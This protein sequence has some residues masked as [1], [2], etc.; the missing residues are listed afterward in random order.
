MWWIIGGLIGWSTRKVLT[1]HNQAK[2]MNKVPDWGD[3]SQKK[4]NRATYVVAGATL[5][6]A[7][8]LAQASFSAALYISAVGVGIIGMR[9]GRVSVKNPPVTYFAVG[10]LLVIGLAFAAFSPGASVFPVVWAAVIIWSRRSPRSFVNPVAAPDSSSSGVAL[11][12]ADPYPAIPEVIDAAEGPGR[13]SAG[14]WYKT[15]SQASMSETVEPRSGRP[16]KNAVQLVT[17]GWVDLSTAT[18]LCSW[19]GPTQHLGK[20]TFTVYRTRRGSLVLQEPATG[21]N[22]GLLGSSNITYQ[23]AEGT[24][25]QVVEVM[26]NKGAAR[27]ARQL[28]PAVL[29]AMRAYHFQSER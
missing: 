9:L 11:N 22:W 6:I 17:G 16:S 27:E 28:F 13:P 25:Q 24:E 23:Y 18:K 14:L 1:Q 21:I 19:E 20:Q 26:V 3:G 4:G 15:T 7:L 29:E 5:L 12:S 8:L 10:G 2:T